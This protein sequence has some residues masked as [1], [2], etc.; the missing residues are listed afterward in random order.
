MSP[1]RAAIA[2]S[3]DSIQIT[4]PLQPDGGGAGACTRARAW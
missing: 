4:D 2:A 1:D 3:A